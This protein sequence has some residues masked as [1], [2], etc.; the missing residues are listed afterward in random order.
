MAIVIYQCNRCKRTIQ[1]PQNE[2]GLE[3]VGKCII[4]ESCHGDLV[5]QKVL[6]TY[7]TG[8]AT[9][10]AA[11]LEDWVQRKVLFTFDQTLKD[12]IWKVDHG[13]GVN[14]SVKTFV[15]DNNG[16]LIQKDPISI[17]FND[18]NN[19][20]ITFADQETG[21]AQCIARST[22][23]F[24]GNIQTVT[25]AVPPVALSTNGILT[26]ATPDLTNAATMVMQFLSPTTFAPLGTANFVFSLIPSISPPWGDVDTISI[27]GLVYKV[28]TVDIQA[29]VDALSLPDATPFYITSVTTTVPIALS[30]VILLLGNTPFSLVDKNLVQIIKASAIENAQDARKAF[31]T[32]ANLFVQAS[33]L[34][35]TYPPIKFTTF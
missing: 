5:F 6:Q 23:P 30:D 25:P 18:S 12:T 28:Q 1:L 35:Q 21:V 19:L 4:T 15:F 17:V 24:G 22:A 20:T 10:L 13:L 3:V 11:G 14:P 9:P 29:A 33:L 27:A 34:Q 26:I 8:Q 32:K 16:V 7:K 2:Q 31:E